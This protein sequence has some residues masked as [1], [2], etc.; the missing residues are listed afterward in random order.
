VRPAVAPPGAPGGYAVASAAA[1]VFDLP[2]EQVGEAA[3]A[4]GVTLHELSGQTESLEDA[5]LTATAA[6]QEY[7]SG[8]PA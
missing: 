6:T 2:I 5:F 3:A 7:R 4:S 8:G 1:D